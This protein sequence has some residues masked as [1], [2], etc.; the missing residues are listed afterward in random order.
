[1]VV[2]T[3]YED[4]KLQGR[5]HELYV[6]EQGTGVQTRLSMHQRERPIPWCS[7]QLDLHKIVQH[8]CMRATERWDKRAS[9]SP[10]CHLLEFGRAQRHGRVLDSC[11]Y[12]LRVRSP[13]NH[14]RNR[15]VLSPTRSP[16]KPDCFGHNRL[17]VYVVRCAH[18]LAP[19]LLPLQALR[20][21]P[22]NSLLGRGQELVVNEVPLPSCPP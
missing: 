12:R 13:R 11:P 20:M 10:C 19:I 5:A 16:Q 2:G 8:I 1:M 17:V 22:S 6:R 15:F 18:S 14:N 21:I 9:G 7:V 4:L 3:E